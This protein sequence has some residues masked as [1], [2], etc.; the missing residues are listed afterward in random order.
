MKLIRFKDSQGVRWGRLED[1]QIQVTAGM[2]GEPTGESVAY[3]SVEVLAPAEPSKIVCVGRNYVDHIKELGNDTGELPREP[4]LFLKAANALAES[5]GEV[6]YPEWSENF[7]FEGELALVIGQ[8]ARNLTPVEVPAAILGY[9]CALD[10]TARDKQKPD[11]QWFRAKAAD[12]FCPLG[13]TLET[14]FDPLDVR[15]QTRVNGETKQDGRTSHMIFDVVQILTYVTRYVTLERG[16]VVLTGTPSGVG[17]LQ[18]G[19]TVQVDIDGLD[20]LTTHIV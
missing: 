14:Q 18:K 17:P 16:D 11:L 6:T 10:L 8:T 12:R 19:D 5:G 13:P 20:T 4:G 2:G 7:H 15:L 3:G 9:T 1:H